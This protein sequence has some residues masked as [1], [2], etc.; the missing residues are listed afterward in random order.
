[1]EYKKHPSKV[2]E[3]LASSLFIYMMIVPFI[4]LDIFLEVYHRV[5]FYL[6]G[7]PYV[8]RGDYII[9]DRH[10]LSY[11]PWYDKINCTYCAYGNGLLLYASAIALETEKYWCAIKHHDLRVPF[12]Q[13]EEKNY[14]DYG[15]EKAFEQ[16]EQK[17]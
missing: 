8:K 17:K 13:E 3:Y 4:I 11:L 5:C 14:L 12:L 10:K 1:M 16:I 7:L 6:Y 15:D 9:F 2:P